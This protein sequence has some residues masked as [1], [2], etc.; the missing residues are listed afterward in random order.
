MGRIQGNGNWVKAYVWTKL[1][2]KLHIAQ[3]SLQTRGGS[4]FCGA[5]MI[6]PYH[7]VTSAHC[8]HDFKGVPK[9]LS[10][11]TVNFRISFKNVLNEI[12]FSFSWWELIWWLAAPDIQ[13]VKF[14]CPA[15]YSWI[16]ITSTQHLKTMWRWSEFRFHFILR[17]SLVQLLDRLLHQFTTK[18]AWLLAGEQRKRHVIAI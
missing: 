14:D 4:H 6:D 16:L 15:E 9:P 18:S 5:T 12:P 7:V 17:I 10:K 1:M 2:L 13:L 3:V 11:V 8:V